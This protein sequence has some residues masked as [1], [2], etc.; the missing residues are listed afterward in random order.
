MFSDILLTLGYLPSSHR[1]E[2][3]SRRMDDK[4]AYFHNIAAS[5]VFQRYLAL[6]AYVNS[7]N[8][9]TDIKRIKSLQYKGGP[10]H[11]QQQHYK[12]LKKYKEIKKYLKNGEKNDSPLLQEFIALH[13]LVSSS[14]F[15]QRVA[16]LKNT[17][18][19]K[20]SSAYQQFLEYR[21]LKKS[22][23]VKEYFYLQKK[24]KAVFHELDNW[25]LLFMDE[26]E[27]QQLSQYWST[28]QEAGLG[29]LNA[30]Y[31]Q[32]NEYHALDAENISV[33]ENK[34]RIAL[35]ADEQEGIAWDEKF[36]FISRDFNCSSGIVNT[37]NLF[38]LRYGKIEV[39][40]R[41]PKLKNVYHAFWLNTNTPTPAIS[42]FNFCNN[43][44]VTGI[45]QPTGADQSRRRLH[46]SHQEFYIVEMKW[47]KKVITWKINGKEVS[48][49][50]NTVNIPLF[51]QLTSGAVGEIQQEKLPQHFDIDWIRVHTKKV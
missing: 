32:N 23:T 9:P 2:K 44:L 4:Y 39:K 16:Y 37:A 21:R 14:A 27:G 35:N 48:R 12:T 38:Q 3:Q 41:V 43:Y 42:L 17:K 10:E 1:Y 5:D 19:Y 29:T 18:K 40:L 36:G 31:V 8:Y 6:D 13:E 49:K 50:A 28:H 26:F 25:K 24:Y 20:E 7:P 22:S 34:L 33:T 15:Q 45:Y 47:G 51:F 46:L 11:L 30:N